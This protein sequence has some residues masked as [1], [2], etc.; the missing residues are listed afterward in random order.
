MFLWLTVTLPSLPP[1]T[2]NT[3][4]YTYL[5]PTLLCYINLVDLVSLSLSLPHLSPH[6][7]FSYLSTPST[8]YISSLFCLT[9]YCFL[10][11]RC[12]GEQ[13]ISRW[14]SLSILIMR[15]WWSVLMVL[16][17]THQSQ[18]EKM[19]TENS[20]P[21]M[22]TDQISTVLNNTYP[23]TFTVGF[24]YPFTDQLCMQFEKFSVCVHM[25]ALARKLRVH[26][27]L[28]MIFLHGIV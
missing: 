12:G 22:T 15:S 10:T 25:S 27:T 23:C 16:T 13:F 26:P 18:L 1:L 3:H 14:P 28:K 17:S 2:V 7:L 24:I 8:H 11:M 19:L 6:T 5:P 21:L 20:S 4:V 9:E